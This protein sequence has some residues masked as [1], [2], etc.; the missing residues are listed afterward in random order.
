VSGGQTSSE[1]ARGQTAAKWLN[2]RGGPPPAAVPECV[3][4][5]G[6]TGGGMTSHGL[7][8]FSYERD[9]PTGELDGSGGCEDRKGELADR[10]DSGVTFPVRRVG[11]TLASKAAGERIQFRRSVSPRFSGGPGPP[12]GA[13]RLPVRGPES[14]WM[15]RWRH[16]SSRGHRLG[17]G[18]VTASTPWPPRSHGCPLRGPLRGDR[19]R[20]GSH[21]P[22]CARR[23]CARAPRVMALQD[24]IVP[25]HYLRRAVRFLL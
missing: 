23:T 7:F 8:S 4:R 25:V 9:A 14:R 6:G 15:R 21:R 10:C 24:W 1:Q 5:P 22:A 13:E 3:A 16:G 11:V 18:L 20:R 17:R 12:C 19:R 2:V